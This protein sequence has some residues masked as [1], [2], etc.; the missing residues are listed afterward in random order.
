MITAYYK[1]KWL[2]LIHAILVVVFG[3]M[4]LSTVNDVTAF[5]ET[6]N[7]TYKAI[8]DSNLTVTNQL[9]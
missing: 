8:C 6:A 5:S 4:L 7:E 2:S 1:N 3:A 9:A